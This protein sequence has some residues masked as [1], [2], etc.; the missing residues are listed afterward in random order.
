MKN[1]SKAMTFRVNEK[2]VLIPV[3]GVLEAYSV[4]VKEYK[5][6]PT[7]LLRKL[8][9]AGARGRK[10]HKSYHNRSYFLV[11]RLNSVT[12]FPLCA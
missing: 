9:W 1:F 3:C 11:L 4:K 8:L 5:L 6:T 10:V 7:T 12:V 2:F